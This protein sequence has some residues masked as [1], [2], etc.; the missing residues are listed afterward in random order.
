[1]ASPGPSDSESSSNNNNDTGVDHTAVPCGAMPTTADARA[2]RRIAALEDELERIRH[3]RGT[4][5][6]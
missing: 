5:Q 2:K 6:R 3:E 4:K 1:M